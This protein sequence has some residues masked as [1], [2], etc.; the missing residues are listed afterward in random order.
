M[1]IMPCWDGQICTFSSLIPCTLLVFISLTFVFVLILN[2]FLSFQSIHITFILF[3][4]TMPVF[5]EPQQ[6]RYLFPLFTYL[7]NSLRSLVSKYQLI[8][9]NLLTGC[10]FII[11]LLFY[12]QQKFFRKVFDN[13]RQQV[14]GLFPII[15]YR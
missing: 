10:E 7:E 15:S 8:F 12:L 6:L 9:M 11:F 5:Q 13:Q 1:I 14:K 4:S 3:I 2:S